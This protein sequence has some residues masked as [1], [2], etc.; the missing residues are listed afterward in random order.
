MFGVKKTLI[1]ELCE[2]ATRN[3]SDDYADF[4]LILQKSENYP[5]YALTGQQILAIFVITSIF[6]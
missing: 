3:F 2:I 5:K 6:A 4:S 1:A